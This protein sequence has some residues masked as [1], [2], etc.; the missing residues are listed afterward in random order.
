M[1]S[2]AVA[3]DFV[4]ARLGAEALLD[5]PGTIP[6]TLNTAYAYQDRAIALFEKALVERSIS[7]WYLRD[8]LLDSIR[9]DSGFR[10]ILQKMGLT[11]KS[12]P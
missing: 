8:P 5:F 4:R 7:P 6:T 1:D 11:S 3:E 12:A 2:E 10:G 9:S